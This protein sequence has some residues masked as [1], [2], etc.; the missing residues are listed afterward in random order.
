MFL[1][2]FLAGTLIDA[3]VSSTDLFI[4]PY[5]RAALS[6]CTTPPATFEHITTDSDSTEI[7]FIIMQSAGYYMARL[8]AIA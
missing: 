1:E 5:P 3:T 8:W 2:N 7:S 4:Y 6:N